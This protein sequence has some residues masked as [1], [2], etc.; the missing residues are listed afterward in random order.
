MT[1]SPVKARWGRNGGMGEG[2]RERLFS[3]RCEKA[4]PSRAGGDRKAT[5]GAVPVRRR[6]S[7]TGIDSRA[8]GFFPLKKAQ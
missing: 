4:G 6:R 3:L 7:L 1:L 8:R 2:W 5:L